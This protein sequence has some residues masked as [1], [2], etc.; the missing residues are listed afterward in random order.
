MAQWVKPKIH[1]PSR[2]RYTHSPTVSYNWTMKQNYNNNRKKRFSSVAT[3]VAQ[4]ATKSAII[5][6]KRT[7]FSISS[8]FFFMKLPQQQQ[9]HFRRAIA[10]RWDFICSKA[11]NLI[12]WKYL[13]FP[14]R[15]TNFILKIAETPLSDRNDDAFFSIRLLNNHYFNCIAN[16]CV[17]F[18]LKWMN[19]SRES[20]VLTTN[21]V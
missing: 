20:I 9:P 15:L 14:L 2:N 5:N 6:L 4:C 18:L 1:F 13:L 7:N 17:I 8:L 10:F 21:H 11:S 16:V 19:E 3:R 12:Q